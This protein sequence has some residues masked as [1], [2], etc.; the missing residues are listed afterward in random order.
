MDLTYIAFPFYRGVEHLQQAAAARS[1]DGRTVVHLV[2]GLIE[3]IPFLNYIV[4]LFDMCI[5]QAFSNA[6]PV[7]G[8]VYYDVQGDDNEEFEP[9]SSS[10]FIDLS[11]NENEDNQL[12]VYPSILADPLPSLIVNSNEESDYTPLE[13]CYTSSSSN[14]D[15]KPTVK[16]ED[17]QEFRLSMYMSPVLTVNN[18]LGNQFLSKLQKEDDDEKYQSPRSEISLQYSSLERN[19]SPPLTPR[20]HPKPRKN[21]PHRYDSGI[22]NSSNPNVSE[23]PSS[24]PNALLQFRHVSVTSKPSSIL[25]L[26][27]AKATA[28]LSDLGG[29]QPNSMPVGERLHL[30]KTPLLE[31]KNNTNNLQAQLKTWSKNNQNC[32]SLQTSGE[33][34]NVPLTEHG[35]I[36]YTLLC[37]ILLSNP[38]ITTL[39]LSNSKGSYISQVLF[40]CATQIE[41]L[42]LSNSDLSKR[43]LSFKDFILANP[44]TEQEEGAAVQDT[45]IF[46]NLRELHLQSV[47]EFFKE[48]QDFTPITK[49]STLE[50]LDLSNNMKNITQENVN[51]IVSCLLNLTT[52]ILDE[53]DNRH[54]TQNFVDRLAKEGLKITLVKP[55]SLDW[56]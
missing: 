19:Y 53:S 41:A 10:S 21:N 52:L 40:A 36:N 56:T 47:N 38:Q 44:T 9:S 35:F 26:D 48:C 15:A 28:L 2:V 16:P 17:D 8:R 20:S 29:F 37:L 13:V 27:D 39:D 1:W 42:D 50:Y 4:A 12:P 18:K 5:T 25:S 30:I 54:I 11:F 34:P 24:L 33:K 14:A 7:S 6:A 46:P 45:P 49:L 32:T 51:T 55:K 23:H 31:F 43:D 3:C 22:S